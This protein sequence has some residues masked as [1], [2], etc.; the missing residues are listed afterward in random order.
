VNILASISVAAHS[1]DE[2][3][4]ARLCLVVR[5]QMNLSL[6]LFSSVSKRALVSIQ[7]S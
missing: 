6:E 4:F 1:L 5:V 3:L 2:E 7:E